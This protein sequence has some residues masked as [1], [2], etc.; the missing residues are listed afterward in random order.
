[1]NA[2]NEEGPIE[3]FTTKKPPTKL[4][5]TAKKFLLGAGV[6][7]MMLAAIKIAMASM[8]YSSNTPRLDDDLNRLNLLRADKIEMIVQIE[9]EI[10]EID[11]QIKSKT[12]DLAESK[13]KDEMQHEEPNLEEVERLSVKATSLAADLG[14][15]K[16][17]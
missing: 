7:V 6:A 15:P 11:R 9:R 12:I 13:I 17:N 4:E 10:E 8:A 1:M 3:T 2:L 5:Q 14:F 16:G